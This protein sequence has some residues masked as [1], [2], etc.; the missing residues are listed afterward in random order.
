[1]S[2]NG[3]EARLD[4]RKWSGDTSGYS[5][6]VERPCQMSGGGGRPLPISGS[7]REALLDVR[8]R[9]EDPP[10]CPEVV[11]RPS[12]YLGGPPGCQGVIGRPS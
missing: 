11:G 2:G 6:V 12:G 8:K 9:S 1:M 4:I 5:G 3:R 10:A 7:D